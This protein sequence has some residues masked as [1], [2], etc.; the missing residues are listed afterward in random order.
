[1]AE[2]FELE[3]RQQGFYAFVE[4]VLGE[5][6][7]FGRQANVGLDCIPGQHVVGLKNYAH[8]VGHA[9]WRLCA[10]KYLDFTIGVRFNQAGHDTQQRSEEHTSEL[11]SLMRI[12]Y[13]VF[14]LK[15]K[16]MKTA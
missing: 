12:S 16:Q 3:N 15:K 2:L 7:N 13:A 10:A 9:L 14:C 8:V 6:A 5:F 1:M 4:L 11:Q